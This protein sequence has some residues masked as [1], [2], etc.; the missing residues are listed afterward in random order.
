MAANVPNPGNYLAGL[1]LLFTGT[2][3]NLAKLMQANK[4]VASMGGETF[5]TAAAPNGLGM[6]TGDAQAL[7]AAL[8]NMANYAAVGNGQ[9]TQATD[10]DFI[11]NTE[12][13]WGG[14]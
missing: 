4:Y 12:P 13:F 9:A 14:N 7:I 10:F 6:A 1:G 2:R 8:G 3:D 5:L 11:G